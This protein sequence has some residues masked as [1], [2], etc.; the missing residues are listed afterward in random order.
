MAGHHPTVRGR[1]RARAGASH[2][3][4][5]HAG[6]RREDARRRLSGSPSMERPSTRTAGERDGRHLLEPRSE[7]VHAW[8]HW[9]RRTGNGVTTSTGAG[10][11]EECRRATTGSAVPLI[12]KGRAQS[13]GS[14]VDANYFLGLDPDG[15]QHELPAGRGLRRHRHTGLN[16]PV[17][18]HDWAPSIPLE[19]MDARRRHVRRQRVAPLRERQ[20]RYRARQAMAAPRR[21]STRSSD[22]R[23]GARSTPRAERGGILPGSMDEV[24]VWDAARTPG[25][26][27]RLDERRG[28]WRHPN[29]IGHWGLNENCGQL[30]PRTPA[31]PGS[32]AN[33]ALV[34]SPTWE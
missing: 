20:P 28:A 23:S 30:R 29:L 1:D 21:G 5:R 10:G 12:S 2:P 11:L 7:S 31:P 25:R 27:P 24:R 13:D 16:H 34:G 22:S 14:N 32:N 4:D 6:R 9:I 17:V 26:G 8:R 19:P 3:A 18:Q 15:S 33:L